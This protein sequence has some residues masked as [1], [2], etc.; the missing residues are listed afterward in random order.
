MNFTPGKYNCFVSPSLLM[1][2]SSNYKNRGG[3]VC[4]YYFLVCHHPCSA[5]IIIVIPIPSFYGFWHGASLHLHTFYGNVFYTCFTSVLRYIVDIC[6]DI[7]RKKRIG[8]NMLCN[9]SKKEF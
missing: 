7:V 1:F 2:T 4:L 9:L 3:Y 6:V 5:C 8:K